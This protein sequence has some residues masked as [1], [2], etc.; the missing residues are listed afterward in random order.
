MPDA[1][2]NQ[3][4]NELIGGILKWVCKAFALAG[5]A[6]LTLIALI[7]VASI[8]GRALFAA[9]I[10]GDFELVQI[11]CAVAVSAF[12]PYCQLQRANIIVDFFTAKSSQR[13][14]ASLDGAGA[15]LVASVMALLA[16]RTGVGAASAK[17]SDETTML[18]GFPLWIAYAA[19]LPSFAAASL[20]GLYTAWSDWRTTGA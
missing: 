4:A 14:Q 16:W 7:A 9:P 18:L 2:S 1:P 8:I 13:V 12:L 19:M 15:L 17:A 6:L 3:L 10:P 20:A 11:A 5:G